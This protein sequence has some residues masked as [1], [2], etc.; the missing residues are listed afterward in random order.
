M[1]I[2]PDQDHLL[3]ALC[4][5]RYAIG[6]QSYI[7]SDGVRWARHYGT[8]SPWLRGILISDLQE[9]A[10]REDNGFKGALGAAMDSTEWREVLAELLVLPAA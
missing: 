1:P 5:I 7:V 8:V 4:A 9:A 3:I 6:R 2:D 10:T